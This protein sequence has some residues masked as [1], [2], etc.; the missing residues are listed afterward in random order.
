M[1]RLPRQPR[2]E[3][4][5]VRNAEPLLLSLLA[6]LTVPGAGAA[7]TVVRRRCLSFRTWI[8]HTI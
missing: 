2:G 6:A 1:C 5:D 4:H 8:P 7:L 3:G